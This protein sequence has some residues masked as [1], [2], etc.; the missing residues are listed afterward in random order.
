M[1]A[2]TD[3]KDQRNKWGQWLGLGAFATVMLVSSPLHAESKARA[4][5]TV[6]EREQMQQRW[7]SL[8]ADKRERLME[9]YE[10]FQQLPPEEQEAMK[11]RYEKWQE[12]P[13]AERRAMRD[14]WAGMSPDERRAARDR[15]HNHDQRNKQNKGGNNKRHDRED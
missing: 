12:I 5:V 6:D 1:G 11:Q 3:M 14:K 13:E 10:R 9:R 7:Q 2:K 4:S 15:V 8:P